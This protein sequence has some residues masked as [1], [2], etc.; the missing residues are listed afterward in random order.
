[1][2]EVK[3]LN[4][5]FGQRVLI[6]N[7]NLKVGNG[8][9]LC[10]LGPNGAGKS[11]LMR[12]LLGLQA[13]TAG[14]IFWRERN[15]FQL[16]PAERARSAAAVFAETHVHGPL[17]LLDFMSLGN[18]LKTPERSEKLQREFPQ[19]KPS[20]IFNSLSDGEKQRLSLLRALWQNPELLYLDEPT[21]HLDPFYTLEFLEKIQRE[22]AERQR[23]FVWSTHRWRFALEHAHRLLILW[24]DGR[25]WLGNP[26]ECKRQKIL[27]ELAISKGLDRVEVLNWF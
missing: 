3:N 8:E 16:D 20:Q 12:T 13:P 22:C 7:L 2:I 14:Q 26:T 4:L 23:S 15:W 17:T 21:S 9:I 25:W 27:Q 6:K 24:G 5:Q 10:I 19:L 11:T 18:S 1:M